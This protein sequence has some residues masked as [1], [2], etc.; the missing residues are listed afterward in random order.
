MKT[1]SLLL[2]GILPGG[3]AIEPRMAPENYDFGISSAA[4][5]PD[6]QDVYLTEVR[7]ADWFNTTDM[8]YRLQYIDP[9]VLRPY[10]ASRWAGLPAAMLAARL[11]QSVGSAP[12]ARG[13]QAKCSLSLYI[14]EFSQVFT[15]EQASRAVLHVRATLTDTSS[16]GQSLVREFQLERPA[17]SPDAAGA[18]AAFANLAVSVAAELNTWIAAAGA[19]RK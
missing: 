17:T 1:L 7:A 11:R 3:C 5:T 19:C 8:L 15:S 16:G 13:R 14:T 6:G 2:A 12:T 4:N 10:S 9:R 18:A